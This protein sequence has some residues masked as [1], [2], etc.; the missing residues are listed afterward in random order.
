MGGTTRKETASPANGLLLH[1]KCHDYIE[2][3]REE[4][5][6]SGW[7]LHQHQTPSAV[8]VWVKGL[9]CQLHDDGTMTVL[10]AEAGRGSPTPR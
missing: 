2:S 7:L 9:L 1:P 3:H 6:A 10:S 4:A 5:L 8:P